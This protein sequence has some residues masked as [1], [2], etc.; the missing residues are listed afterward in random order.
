MNEVVIA[1]ANRSPIG[2]ANKGS[3]KG[4][5]PDDLAA[6]IVDSVL[7]DLPEVVRG[8]VEDL[9]LGC[10]QP[11]GES[12][13]NIARMVALRLGL[14]TLPGTTVNRYCASSM[15]SIRMAAH[16]VA[17]GEGDVFVAG[18]V[19]T[20]SRYGNGKADGMADTKNPVLDYEQAGG[21]AAGAY[22][23]MGITAENVAALRGV[24]REQ[25]DEYA[26]RS[27]Q[28]TELARQRGFWER[29]ITPVRDELGRLVE[30]DDSPRPATT[31]AGL[32]ELTP[33]FKEHGS[34]TAGNACP[35]SDGAAAVV[36]M[37]E[38]RA[39]ELEIRPLAR[40]VSTAV[41]G[42]APEIM[43]LGP[44][45]STRLALARAGMQISDID[46]IEMNEAFAAQVVAS[47]EEL[48]L[49]WDRLNVNGGAIA[50]GHP[51]GMTGARMITTLI[52][53]LEER[54]ATIGLA[55]LCVGGGQGMAVVIERVG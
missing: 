30:H 31:L 45:A 9:I 14:K 12:G 19:E 50:L 37:S 18:G 55:T 52:N 5:R 42:V 15:Q 17:A 35:L 36:V 32:A 16:A 28:R 54:D 27:Q 10:A 40:I 7:G 11:A 48:Q 49:P 1:A 33:V 47:A 43:G 25:Q 26:L 6:Q 51:F 44:V 21:P 24:T 20:V 13:Y 53:G 29:D 22:L 38:R 46:L 3:L 34:V 2:R 4:L 41:T 39:Q 23:P 8:D